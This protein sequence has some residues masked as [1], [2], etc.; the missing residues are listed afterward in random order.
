MLTPILI[1]L[2]Y[3][4]QTPQNISASLNTWLQTDWSGGNGQTSWSDDTKY[5]VSSNVVA[6]DSISLTNSNNWNDSNWLY[7]K[8]ITFNNSAQA[9]N[10]DNFIAMVNLTSDNFD[11]T[12]TKANGEDIRFF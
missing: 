10:L 8:K 3:L 1:S 2:I 5:N 4:V 9:E 12:K 6:N 11:F 7:R